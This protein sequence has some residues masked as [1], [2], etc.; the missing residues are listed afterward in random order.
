[1]KVPP[2]ITFR[3]LRSS[4]A[5]VSNI[6]ERIGWLEHFSN[7]IISCHVVVES[8][9]RHHQ[10][11]N[12]FHVRIDLRLPGQEIVISREPSAHKAH[13]DIYVTIHDAFDEARRGLEE[14]V[15]RRRKDI[16]NHIAPPH[17]YV[18][19]LMQEDGGFGFIRTEDGRDLYF[20]SNTV[21]NH[22]YDHLEV[23]TEVRYSEEVGEEGPQASTIEVVGK[24]GRRFRVA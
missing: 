11:G 18:V 2:Q 4:N 17:A 20:H 22:Q 16:K 24:A 14:Y 13:K 5:I 8:P 10:R 7:Q 19:R 9:H 6:R 15:R 1:M 23:G 12:L 3:H 21:L